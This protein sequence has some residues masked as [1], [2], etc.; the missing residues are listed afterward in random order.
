[1][2]S[3][4]ENIINSWLTNVVTKSNWTEGILHTDTM[5]S[6][7][8]NDINIYNIANNNCVLTE[9]QTV[10]VDNPFNTGQ[11]LVITNTGYASPN[12]GGF[13]FD[14]IA[15]SDRVIITRFWAKIPI[16]YQVDFFGDEIGDNAISYW[17]SSNQGTGVFTEYV[18]ILICGN[19]GTFSKANSFALFGEAGT[20]ENPITWSIASASS[21]DLSSS[22]Y[23]YF[24][25]NR[26]S[27]DL[28]VTT[29]D[30]DVTKSV[31]VN[32]KKNVD[33]TY[34][35]I[36]SNV[37]FEE[38]EGY[39]LDIGGNLV[40]DFDFSVTEVIEVTPNSYIIVSC[41]LNEDSS[42]V[43]YFDYNF[44]EEEMNTPHILL[45]G[46]EV[47]EY[48]DHS[49][50]IPA[51][52]RYIRVCSMR[53]IIPIEIKTNTLIEELTTTRELVEEVSSKSVKSNEIKSI[54]I[55]NSLPINQEDGVLYGIY[56]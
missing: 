54:V 32:V 19:T 14:D 39:K 28:A 2:A 43:G 10:S 38:T 6:L 46:Q 40:E 18:N 55:T 51:E 20:I 15:F 31:L 30:L 50:T 8:M 37:E 9:L 16:G 34:K 4:V 52:I 41:Y 12:L 29:L 42:V 33:V 36:Y 3:P 35:A 24:Q 5:F 11:E 22:Y 48:I 21:Y 13:S 1:M 56:M 26:I 27:E 17:Y 44:E 25:T 49:L 23:Q 45:T 7:G 53:E 47:H